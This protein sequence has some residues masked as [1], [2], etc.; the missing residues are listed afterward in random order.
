[1][2]QMFG[3]YFEDCFVYVGVGIHSRDK[4]LKDVITK[5]ST[6]SYWEDEYHN[7]EAWSGN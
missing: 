6:W 7:W 1:M 2:K 3:M 4:C 5:I